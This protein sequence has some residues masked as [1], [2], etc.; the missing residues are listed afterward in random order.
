MNTVDSP[1]LD[2]QEKGG[3]SEKQA[4]WWRRHLFQLV[5][6]GLN[7]ILIILVAGLLL[8]QP[9]LF[10]PTG[11]LTGR[12]VNARGYPIAQ[13]QVFVIS[14]ERWVAVDA[15]GRFVIDRVPVG[16]TVVLIVD[17]PPSV[18]PTAPPVGALVNI[19]ARQTVD[20]GIVALAH[21]P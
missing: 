4:P 16:E 9:G 14:A 20:L 1:E 3:P 6:G 21:A 15:H 10:E 8:S 2:Y 17:A 7:L 18:P 5:L 12:V 13:A 19:V 11:S